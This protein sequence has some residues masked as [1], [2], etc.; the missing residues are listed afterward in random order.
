MKVYTQE[1][2]IPKKELNLKGP[3]SIKECYNLY[4]RPKLPEQHRIIRFVITKTDQDGY[5]S[6]L[7]AIVPDK[8]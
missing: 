2:L 7:D 5:H 4:I 8:K 3:G 1:L 6:E